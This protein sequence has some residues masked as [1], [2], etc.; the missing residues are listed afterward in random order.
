M[1]TAVMPPE[2]MTPPT[3]TPTA[4]F[5]IFMTIPPPLVFL[6][7]TLK[8]LDKRGKARHKLRAFAMEKQMFHVAPLEFEID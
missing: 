5:L 2:K 6:L 3:T 7:F 4:M 8:R 1:P